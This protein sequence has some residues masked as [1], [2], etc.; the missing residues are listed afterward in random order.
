MGKFAGRRAVVTGTAMGIGLGI[1]QRLADEDADLLLLDI[2]AAAGQKVVAR[3]RGAGKKHFLSCDVGSDDAVKR[4]AA[5]ARECWGSVDFIVNNAG[6]FPRCAVCDLSESEWRRV[7]DTNLGGAFHC[8]K[9]FAPLMTDGKGAIVNISSGRALEGAVN[10]VAYSATK[11]GLLGLTRALAKEFAPRGIRVNALVPG[12]TDTQ[13]PRL[14]MTDEQLYG[15][16][17][18]IPLGR[19]AEPDDIAKGVSFLLSDDAA[20]MTGQKLVINGGAIMA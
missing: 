4:A 19:I 14:E 3:L 20:Y 15:L 8:V 2:D 10:A 13:Q 17:R 9:Y 11:A 16:G 1:A 12:V 6:I 18:F 7:I 5:F